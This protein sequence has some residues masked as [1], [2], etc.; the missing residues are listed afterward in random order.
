MSERCGIA[1]ALPTTIVNAASAASAGAHSLCELSRP[2]SNSRRMMANAATLVAT[3]MNDVI[4]V[5]A[6]WYTSGVHWWNGATD[7]LNAR[8]TSASAMPVRSSGSSADTVEPIAFTI[9]SRLVVLVEP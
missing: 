8:P 7:A 9:P 3:A 5:G 6:P 1:P 2:L 4:G